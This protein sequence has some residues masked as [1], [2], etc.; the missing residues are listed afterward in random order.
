MRFLNKSV[1]ALFVGILLLV[2]LL[3]IGLMMVPEQGA[4]VGLRQACAGSN[5]CGDAKCKS[6]FGS[7][8]ESWSCFD[9]GNGT[10]YGDCKAF[11]KVKGMWT[12]FIEHCSGSY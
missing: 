6:Q 7:Y 10:C 1:R 8:Y 12:Y 11:I 5:N 9:Q 3:V 4:K 2:P